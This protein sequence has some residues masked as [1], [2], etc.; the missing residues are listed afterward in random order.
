FL[1]T[2]DTS[3]ISQTIID[4]DHDGSVVMFETGED[5][6]AILTGFTITNG[7]IASGQPLSHG[8]GICCKN[9]SPTITN[10]S[11][12]DNFSHND[13]AGIY[14]YFCSPNLNNLTIS[15]NTTEWD[16]AGLFCYY[17]HPTLYRVLIC[18][19]TAA[20]AGSGAYLTASSEPTFTNVTITENKSYDSNYF[21]GFQLEHD[22]SPT[23][24]N[25]ILWNN[26]P[27]EIVL[28]SVCSIDITYS[29]IKGGW[30]GL[31]NMNVD[32]L[33][34]DPLDRDFHLTTESLCIDNGD[35]NSPPD[36]DGSIAD[37]G[38]YY[39]DPDYFYANFIAT[40]TVGSAPL[41]VS[42]TDLSNG[43]I[44]SWQWDFQNDGI[45]DSYEQN[46]T[47]TYDEQ[48]INSVKLIVQDGTNTDRLIKEDY[49]F[50]TSNI[51]VD[52]YAFLEDQSSHNGIKI[53][54]ER[55]APS[56]ILDSTYTD[57]SGYF[58]INLQ[59]GWFDITYSKEDYHQEILVYQQLNTHTT[60]TN[61][62]L[63]PQG[64]GIIYVPSQFSTI[65][66]AIDNAYDG[67]IVLV[68][69]GR[70]Y[71]NINF[72]GKSITVSSLFLTIQD[73][74]YIT[75][76]I[77]DA[78]QNGTVVKFI[79]GEDSLSC[80]NGF[81]ITGG[82]DDFGGICC[83]NSNP[84]L[85]NLIVCGNNAFGCGGGIFC[86]SS[87]PIIMN[88]VIKDNTVTMWDGGGFFCEENSKPTLINVS[89]YNNS[90][91]TFGGGISCWSNT[92]P[93]FYN[94]DV[95]DNTA[96]QCGGV[97]CHN[98]IA[99]LTNVTICRNSSVMPYNANGIYSVYMANVYVTNCI[100]WDNWPDEIQ[101]N[102]GGLITITYSDIKDGWSGTGNID[103]DPLFADPQN[104]DF[105]LTWSSYPF[106]DSTKSPCIDTG[107][108]SSPLDPDGTCADMGA[109]YYDQPEFGVGIPAIPE[110]NILHQN[111]PNPTKNSTTIQYSLKQN[112][113]V[114]ISIYNIKG[115]LIST[116]V[117]ETKPKGEYSVIF[118]TE[119]LSSGVY[120]YKIQTEYVSEIKKII[121]IK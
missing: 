71:E 43:N 83:Y 120:F 39:F 116:I 56:I 55:T 109:Y 44:I 12:V 51:V 73:S 45:I 74:T 15:G 60:L 95:H 96:D 6:T 91:G 92:Q 107:D 35:P 63:I 4:G 79:N 88:V 102:I 110:A 50:V 105:H 28:T 58:E 49:I 72:G 81:T 97:Y 1:T 85:E 8:A 21:A 70:Y 2:Q 52:G 106:P 13:G 29:D 37:I 77:I 38:A 66:S 114:I 121:V 9:S 36:P 7:Y 103:S 18:N 30:T 115:Q 22:A 108:P 65:Q 80:L 98:S 100:I 94:V 59:N 47:F 14:C 75:N 101:T 82:Y 111:Y 5:T 57:S 11:I 54:F 113:N 78:N 26:T 99:F 3:Y 93:S 84:R 33:F 24:L 46:P 119:A 40:P 117:N 69:S 90:A 61:I 23:L 34:V 25:C 67:N 112:S 76:T 41:G 118:N 10:S 64:T 53:L 20:W 17:A 86:S 68:D 19:N 16:G 27:Q 48:G 104:G 31:G 89:I 87:D 42:F 62:T 32:P